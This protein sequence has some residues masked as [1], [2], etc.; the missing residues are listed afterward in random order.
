MFPRR[1]SLLEVHMNRRLVSSSMFLLIVNKVTYE[2]LI[3]LYCRPSRR[4]CI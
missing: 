1:I 2:Q 4:K 3:Y